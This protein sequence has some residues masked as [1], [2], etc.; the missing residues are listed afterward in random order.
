[1]S[2]HPI[3]SDDH[4]PLFPEPPRMMPKGFAEAK[5][6]TRRAYELVDIL[7]ECEDE[8]S[9]DDLEFILDNIG[10]E[11]YWAQVAGVAIRR[12]RKLGA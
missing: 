3:G 1:M 11:Y 7:S 8:L 2:L 9:I 12:L 6:R 5:D 4:S 10:D